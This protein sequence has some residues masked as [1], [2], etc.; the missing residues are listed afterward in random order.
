MSGGSSVHCKG[1]ATP[2]LSHP[3]QSTRRENMPES[4]LLG[5]SHRSDFSVGLNIFIGQYKKIRRGK[6]AVKPSPRHFSSVLVVK[7]Q[8]MSSVIVCSQ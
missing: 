3:C 6:T 8:N 7:K 5:G 4:G 2:Q 1:S